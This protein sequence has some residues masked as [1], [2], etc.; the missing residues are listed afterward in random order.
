MSKKLR[1]IFCLVTLL[2]FSASIPAFGWDEIISFGDSLSDNGRADNYGAYI[3]SNGPVWLDYLSDSM[4]DVALED[5]AICGAQTDGPIVNGFDIGM[6]RQVSDYIDSLPVDADLSG[7]LY[8]MWIGGNDLL[9]PLLAPQPNV[10]GEPEILTAINNIYY[11]LQALAIAGAEDILIMNL[12]DLGLCPMIL[13]TPYSEVYTNASIAF[14]TYLT[15]MVCD[16][17]GQF[18]QVKFYIADTFELLQYVVEN[19]ESL[20]FTNVGGTCSNDEASP[21]CEGYLFYDGIHPTSATHKYLAALAIGQVKNSYVSEE[22]KALLKN[23]N[24]LQPRD[25]YLVQCGD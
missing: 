13:Y 9:A 21:E 24:T 8:T 20:G 25:Y 18:P 16:L 10:P 5:R 7:I 22:I 15:H 4:R 23:L 19:G 17:R 2:V 1:M 14:N 11:A 6:M 12:P 3:A